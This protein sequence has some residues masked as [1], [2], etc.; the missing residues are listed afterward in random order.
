MGC[1]CDAVSGNMIVHTHHGGIG[2]FLR[3]L[4]MYATGMCLLDLHGDQ[5]SGQKILSGGKFYHH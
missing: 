3:E 1:G 2:L 4:T 5:S